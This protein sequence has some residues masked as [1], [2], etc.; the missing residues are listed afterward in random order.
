MFR[1][2]LKILFLTPLLFLSLGCSSKK[3][4][5]A[6]KR[7]SSSGSFRNVPGDFYF[8]GMTD[9]G[10]GIYKF[11]SKDK[12]AS[13]FWSTKNE[14]VIELSNSP[15]RKHAFFLTAAGF[16]KQ[17]VFTFVNDVKL[18]KINI[19]SSKAIFVQ[20]I[21]NGIQVFTAWDTGNTFKVIFN[22]FDKTVA[23]FI[24]QETL[25]FSE[26]GR[27]LVDNTKT[28]DITKEGYPKP[29]ISTNQFTSL[30]GKRLLAIKDSSKYLIYLSKSAGLL[31][32]LITKTDQNLNYAAWTHDGKYLIFSTLDISQENQSLHSANPSTSKL[33]VYSLFE[34]RITKAWNGAGVKNFFIKGSFLI[35]DDGFDGSSAIHIFNYRTGKTAYIIRVK[36]GCGLRNIPSVPNY[37]S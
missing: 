12:R 20:K 35:F 2:G 1:T 18:Y 34:K 37:G 29:P 19:N 27:K 8:V 6:E 10:A 5:E 15:D 16:G 13:R 3:S 4:N 23:N 33:Y 22:S 11:Q 30:K 25:I 36:G 24:N 9:N 21:G 7:A 14:Q 17:G 31:P 32:K 28:Y 26:F